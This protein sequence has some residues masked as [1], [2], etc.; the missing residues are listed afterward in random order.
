MTLSQPD[1]G[2]IVMEDVMVP[3]RD[4]V[5]LATDVY[6]PARHGE[7]VSGPLPVILERTPYNKRSPDRIERTCR[8]FARRGYVVV[9]QDC[10]ACY[11][12]E[13]E[14]G[15]F[16]QEG[17]DGYE[18]VEWTA[19][20]SWCNG[21]IGT[22][23]TS[24]AGWTQ[25]SLAVLDPPH[26]TCMWVNEGASNGYTST[27]RH[28][29]ALE[30]RFLT[31]LYWH[32][33]TNTNARLKSDPA[34]A[35]ALESS[36]TREILKHLP[37]REGQT[38]LSYAPA[39]ERLAIQLQTRGDYDDLWK[40][41]S[42][43]FELH[44]DRFAD[45]PTV[46]SSAWYD[47]Y[48]RANLENFV[49]LSKRKKGPFRLIMGP[50][51]HGDLPISHTFSGGI[52]LGRDAPM[53]YDQERLR[54]FDRWLKDMDTGVDRGPS[55]RIFVMGGGSGRKDKEG[56]LDHGGHWR[57]EDQWPLPGAQA[58][59]YYLHPDGSL[60]SEPPEKG[61][62][63]TTYRYDPNDPVPTVG[64]NISSLATLRPIPPFISDPSSLPQAYRVE[65][66]VLAGGWD[67]REREDVYGARPPYN[68]P[69]SDRQDVLVFQ[70]PPL[71]RDTEVTGPLEVNLW[72]SSDAPDTDF[73]AKLIDVYP[74]SDDYPDGFA[75]NISDSI[76]RMRYRD[77]WEKPEMM[78]PG[79]VYPVTVTLYPTS[80]LFVRGHRIRL[81]VSSSNFPRFDANP[82]TGE[83]LGRNTKT[84]VATNTVHHNADHPSH[85]VLPVV[86]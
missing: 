59:S 36:D 20:Q 19:R 7:P 4:G 41:P 38:P 63:F 44:W 56:R 69:L 39:Y 76:F 6:L 55:V 29:G 21:R 75:L 43:N 13:G 72:V 83:P 54:W 85:V 32:A 60:Q 53:D 24:Y 42:V 78:K 22:T 52:D 49:G 37:V 18:T 11:Q 84:Q 58:V 50:W 34:V 47:S 25:N 61:N 3:V 16:W 12:S 73:T 74:P 27:L 79:V 82:N 67:Q 45:V 68:A 15:F 46:F 1:Y 77:S 23:G 80:S 33:G 40:D 70:T 62:V 64:G 66:I 81:D 57:D 35:R 31:W 51:T 8:Y 17:P 28:G 26:L 30:L 9:M 65:Q 86:G 5:R 48:T 14:F 10:R 71:E 2:V